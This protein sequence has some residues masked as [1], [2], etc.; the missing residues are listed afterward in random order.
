MYPYRKALIEAGKTLLHSG[1][2]VET[3]GN[4]SLRNPES[5]LIY[6]TPSGMDY[7]TCTEE[8]IVVLFPDGRISSGTRKPSVEKDLHLAIYRTRPK[9]NAIIH[10]HPIYSTIFSCIGEPIPLFLD[11]AAQA[12]STP[13]KVCP[14]ALPGSKELAK[15]C[16]S[17][18]SHGENAC[19]LK[20]HGAVCIGRTQ[21]EAFKTAKV[22]EM[23]AEIYWRIRAIGKM[24]DPLSPKAIAYMRDFA[25]HRYGQEK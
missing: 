20:S 4:L 9:I 8:D 13:V 18:L 2:T 3:W 10:T 25:L 15:A 6:L 21:K 23:T 22:L 5:G 17:A 16:A 11:E 19:L 24:P 1:L 12:L 7:E 14:Y